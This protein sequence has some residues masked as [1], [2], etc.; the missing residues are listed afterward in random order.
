MTTTKKRKPSQ[1]RLDKIRRDLVNAVNAALEVHEHLIPEHDKYES[2]L[3]DLV[4]Q[5]DGFKVDKQKLRDFD[6]VL[7]FVLLTTFGVDGSDGKGQANVSAHLTNRQTHPSPFI[8]ELPYTHKVRESDEI[9][10]ADLQRLANLK[11]SSAAK[12]LDRVNTMIENELRRRGGCRRRLLRAKGCTN[13]DC[14]RG[15]ITA[16]YDTRKFFK[17]NCTEF[18]RNHLLNEP[19]P[20]GGYKV[21]CPVCQ[22]EERQAELDLTMEK[23]P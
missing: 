13:K 9:V 5:T 20:D 7:Y 6:S 4:E 17:N 21:L 11:A 19:H 12:E 22:T 18:Q 10:M 8:I 16:D 14:R 23:V 2:F 15:L 1:K 3:E